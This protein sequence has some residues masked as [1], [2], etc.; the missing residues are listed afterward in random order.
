[1]EALNPT[2][3]DVDRAVQC[4][5]KFVHGRRGISTTKKGAGNLRR[6]LGMPEFQLAE[7]YARALRR[8]L[9]APRPIRP[10][11]R[12]TRVPGSGIPTVLENRSSVPLTGK[13]APEV[14]K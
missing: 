8:R 5:L 2:P 11:P 9:M 13:S 10:A 12:S 6:P 7:A 1:M 14:T 3:A 4:S